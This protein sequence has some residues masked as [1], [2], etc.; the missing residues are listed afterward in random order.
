MFLQGCPTNVLVGRGRLGVSD[1]WRGALEAVLKSICV[2]CC[3]GM[4][5]SNVFEATQRCTDSDGCDVMFP[6]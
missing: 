4:F 3:A 1:A 6:S 5:P 2:D